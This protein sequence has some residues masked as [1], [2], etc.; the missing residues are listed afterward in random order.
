MTM[1]AAWR[2]SLTIGVGTLALYMVSPATF[3]QS[4][5]FETLAILFVIA[6]MASVLM[7]D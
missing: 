5:T 1:K 4:R 3:N 2:T 7:D 6:T